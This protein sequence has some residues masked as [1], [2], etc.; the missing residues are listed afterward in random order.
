VSVRDLDFVGDADATGP[1]TT[2]MSV[3]FMGS[4]R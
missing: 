1:G 4:Y 3:T 2:F